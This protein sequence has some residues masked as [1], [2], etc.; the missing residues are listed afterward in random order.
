LFALGVIVI[1]LCKTPRSRKVVLS[2]LFLFGLVVPGLHTY[3][4]DLDGSL[5]VSPTTAV[6]LF[7]NDPTFNNVYKRGHTNISCYMLGLACGYLVYYL[8]E[9][10]FDVS[11]YKVEMAAG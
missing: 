4:Q 5:I 6:D 2:I 1:V 3:F 9:T 8:Q 11:K 10:N 7:V